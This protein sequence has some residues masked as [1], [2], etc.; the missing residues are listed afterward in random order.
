MNK[1]YMNFI[2]KKGTYTP[3]LV[4]HGNALDAIFL[5][6]LKNMLRFTKRLLVITLQLQ[7]HWLY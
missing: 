2:S 1:L 3:C 7:N 4:R 5:S 6:R